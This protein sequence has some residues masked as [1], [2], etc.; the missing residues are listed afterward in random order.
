M[1]HDSALWHSSSGKRTDISKI[2]IFYYWVNPGFAPSTDIPNVHNWSISIPDSFS[3]AR[4]LLLLLRITLTGFKHR[5]RCNLHHL[6][7]ITAEAS[8]NICAPVS[9]T[10]TS[11]CR[12][13]HILWWLVPRQPASSAEC[14][15]VINNG[16]REKV[17]HQ[18]NWLRM[19][20]LM[21][22]LPVVV[23]AFV[24]S[25]IKHAVMCDGAMLLYLNNRWTRALTFTHFTCE[26]FSESVVV[27]Q[28][29]FIS[30]F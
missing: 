28:L 2:T 20:A 19:A 15:S 5:P 11:T 17:C 26:Y 9:V 16:C 1:Q 29:S 27:P 13:L 18:S 14:N 12:Q 25:Q 8:C 10:D 22:V 6:T 21:K 7:V 3:Q 30:S 23:R 24:Y 4:P